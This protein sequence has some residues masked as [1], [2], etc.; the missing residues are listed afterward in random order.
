MA[1]T[2]DEPVITFDT[3]TNGNNAVVMVSGHGA[4]HSGK[5]SGTEQSG[6]KLCCSC[7]IFTDD[8]GRCNSAASFWLNGGAA[9]ALSEWHIYGNRSLCALGII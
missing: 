8:Y 5:R 6:L 2:A 9:F 1:I 3:I 4:M 7:T